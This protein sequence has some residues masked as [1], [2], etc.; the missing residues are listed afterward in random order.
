MARR[1]PRLEQTDSLAP[2]RA[3]GRK[4]KDRF[5]RS[6]G[7]YATMLAY[8][9]VLFSMF[10][11]YESVI[12]DESGINYVAF[13]IAAANA[14]VLSKV[15]LVADEL[16]L[17]RG[18]ENAPLVVPIIYRS[19]VFAILFIVF[20]LVERSVMGMLR[21]ETPYESLPSWS[22]RP[23]LGTAS[24][25]ILVT[26]S[27]VPYFAFKEVDKALGK[28]VLRGLIFAGGRKPGALPSR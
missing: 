12:S 28:G 4:L 7:K 8:L 3:F 5:F 22:G 20:R 26:L 24:V 13:G 10:A 21:G 6:F 25:G 9:W 16:N 27:L 15:M 14:V 11:L 18:F 2:T 19:L 1:S 23:L 17:A